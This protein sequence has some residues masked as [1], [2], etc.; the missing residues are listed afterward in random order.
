MRT[1]Y[2]FLASFVAL[3]ASACNP[4]EILDVPPATVVESGRAI[5]DAVSARAAAA[6]LYDALQSQD[7]YGGRMVVMPEFLSDNAAHVGTFTDFREADQNRL[8]ALNAS[9]SGMWA[10]VYRAIGRANAVIASVPGVADLTEAERD[11]I[12]GEAYFVRALSHL[13]ATVLWGDAPLVTEVIESPEEAGAVTNATQADLYRQIHN[14]LDQAEA[15]LSDDAASTQ[16]N[17]GAAAALRARVYLFQKQWA[18]AEAQAEKVL[19]MGYSLAPEYADL[20]T[21]SGSATSEDIFRL[22]FN[23]QDSNILSY[24][25]LAKPVG[26]RLEVGPTAGFIGGF[27]AGDERR[28]ATIASVGSTNYVSKLQ[29]GLAGTE[30]VHIIRL[31]EI[32]LIKAEAEAQQGKLADAV[33]SYNLIRA[34][35]GLAPHVLGVDVT[36]QQQV[37]DAIMRERRYELAFEGFRWQD[38][39]RTGTAVAV[40]GLQDRPHQVLLP[41]PNREIEISQISQNPG[42]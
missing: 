21:P 40:L 26:G 38:L 25:Y 6:G 20:F 41:I 17:L 3:G 30:H 2:L 1:R 19:A 8:N 5:T 33:A 34:R 32:I 37:L 4:D 22:A 23:D 31:A 27:Q 10:A 7:Y 28:A 39:T 35:A 29:S 16:A 42:Y 15:L 14:D 13:N 24:W 9:V 36:T 11:Q 12:L 18:A